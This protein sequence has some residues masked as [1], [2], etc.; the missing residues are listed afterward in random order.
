MPSPFPGMDP[1]LEQSEWED[2]HLRF[3]LTLSEAIAP[4]IGPRYVVRAERRVYVESGG[5][6]SLAARRPDIAI[7]LRH[8]VAHF[9]IATQP[10]S[11]SGSV[12]CLLSEPDLH[13]E[14]YLF[15]RD[16]RSG[17]VV[18]VIE[19]LSP[20]NKRRGSTGQREYLSKRE[21]VLNS[22][23]NLVELDFLRSG[24]RPPFLK[25]P[26]GD[27]FAMVS[28]APARPT[29]DVW[30]WSLL[31]PL[32]RIPIPLRGDDTEPMVSLQEVFRQT[33]EKAH[34]EWSI[35]YTRPLDP[36]LS[37]EESAPLANLRPQG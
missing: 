10:E 35:D 3:N 36:P 30:A 5:D 33:F 7:E 29:I 1:Y 25:R 19:T 11:E 18:T 16:V 21:M 12:A 6:R 14:T 31:K 4:T 9:E 13:R 20:A 17:D 24:D 34:Y 26:A 32:P 23:T 15:I 37:A 8:P 28:R 22:P 27:Y 2:F